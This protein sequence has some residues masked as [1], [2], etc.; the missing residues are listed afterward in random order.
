[1]IFTVKDAFIGKKRFSAF[2]LS[3]Q[4]VDCQ[5]CR[6][7]LRSLDTSGPR[8]SRWQR[9]CY[10]EKSNMSLFFWFVFETSSWQIILPKTGKRTYGYKISNKFE[11]SQIDAAC[12]MRW[13]ICLRKLFSICCGRRMNDSIKLLLKV[14]KWAPLLCFGWRCADLSRTH[15]E[16]AATV[17]VWHKTGRLSAA[18]II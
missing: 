18:L 12:V 17:N 3:V 7:R 16:E 5:G 9:S 15:N 8:L 11:G 14:E 2:S 13:A 1:M 4:T 6:T 10:T